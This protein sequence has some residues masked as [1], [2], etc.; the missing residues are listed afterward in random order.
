LHDQIESQKAR[1]WNQQKQISEY[2]APN[3]IAQ[4]IAHGTERMA[5]PP[6]PNA[7]SPTADT[8]DTDDPNAE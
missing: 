7:I 3:A 2:T 1:L 6:P 4:T 8:T 5:P